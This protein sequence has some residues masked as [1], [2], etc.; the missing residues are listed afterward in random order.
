MKYFLTVAFI[1]VTIFGVKGQE[2]PCPPNGVYTDPQD[3]INPQ[4]PEYVNHFDWMTP[5]YDVYA[6]GGV[7]D[8]VRNPYLTNQG[9]VQNLFDS[10]DF[11][12]EDGWEL[13]YVDF[14][15]TR[16]GEPHAPGEGSGHL[17]F[18]LYNKHRSIIRV[19]TSIF[20]ERDNTNL[21]SIKLSSSGQYATALLG[22]ID[23]TQQPLVSFN[24]GNTI[25]ATQKFFA[26][27]ID[28]RRWHYADFP[29]NYD[30]CTCQGD[31]GDRELGIEINLLSKAEINL[32]GTSSGTIQIIDKPLGSGTTGDW[33]KFYGSVKAAGTLIETGKKGFKAFSDFKQSADASATGKSK[34]T[35]IKSGVENLAG[36][37]TDEAP[38][39]KAVPYVSEALAI[40]DFFVGGSKKDDG[41]QKVTF[42]PMSM[43]L[44][45]NF[46][47][48]LQAAF[49]FLGTSI[50]TPGSNFT[51]NTLPGFSADVQYPIY[52]EVLGA[53][54]LLEKPKIKVWKGYIEKDWD[55]RH[56]GSGI[57]RQMIIR[58]ID[59]RAFTI[60]PS[61]I[62]I[63][64]N[65]ASG[66]TL[67]E[68]YVQLNFSLEQTGAKFED[69]SEGVVLNNTTWVSPLIPLSCAGERLVISDI[70]REREAHQYT[71]DFEPWPS[72]T[73]QE[74]S[75]SLIL[76]FKNSS[77]E[78]I[79]Y[80]STWAT[81]VEDA[82]YY[83]AEPAHTVYSEAN[84]A[85]AERETFDWFDNEW[86]RDLNDGF[87]KAEEHLSFLYETIENDV[88]AIETITIE[89]S[90]V[91]SDLQ[92][93]E[94]DGYTNVLAG[95]RIDLLPNS[96][97]IPNSV[98]EISGIGMN[99]NAPVTLASDNEISTACSSTEY[100]SRLEKA[101]RVILPNAHTK[102]AKFS[103]MIYPNPASDYINILIPADFNA[104]ENVTVNIQD[105]AGRQVLIEKRLDR[106]NGYFQLETT[107][108]KTGIYLLRVQAGN[109]SSLQ[110]VHI[111]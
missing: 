89:N 55:V 51:P 30:P 58:A 95:T 91:Q 11:K 2:E 81:D 83:S 44:E 74:I 80:K 42:P 69:Y 106:Q 9:A 49:P 103:F 27:N 26:S 96:Q 25:D 73:H 65:K 71:G 4:H 78:T 111:K 50:Y 18:M 107:Q 13:V 12:T 66:L 14:G 52:N 8:Q 45:H 90:L 24:P 110:K 77:G 86:L 3:P 62:K 88:E 54:T 94:N 99:C 47:G 82:D 92:N 38:V 48:E 93:P 46:S 87:F 32:T 31:E 7:V 16:D 6:E 34:E 23:K 17:W 21:I 39:L 79:L 101:N 35:K 97:V 28:Q 10:D 109:E 19:F 75:L 61:S 100:L 59:R 22:A 20:D 84:S 33:D 5:F 72:I 64:V 98:L 105:M 43:Q 37:L 57:Y 70:K 40:I 36:F 60:D 85:M 68:A 76:N 108:F 15:L 41:P 63:A 56:L 67:S 29:V 102:K 53:Y 1:I 104:I